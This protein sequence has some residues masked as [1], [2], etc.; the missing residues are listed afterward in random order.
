MLVTVAMAVKASA[1]IALPFLGLD[2]GGAPTVVGA[3]NCC[4]PE[5]GSVALFGTMFTGITVLSGVNLGSGPGPGRTVADCR[6]D[7]LPTAAGQLG[8]RAGFAIR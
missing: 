5:R 4:E 6:L 8:A 2:L 3:R 7:A 1:G